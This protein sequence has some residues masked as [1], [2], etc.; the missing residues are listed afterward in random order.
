MA[1][2]HRWL[3]ALAFVVAAPLA[4]ESA[5]AAPKPASQPISL[6]SAAPSAARVGGSTY[7]VTA[8][9]TSGLPV[10]F[11]IDPTTTSICSISG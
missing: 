1:H 5:H 11:T 4:V 6:T 9:A 8:T 7:S 2:T 10:T 3:V